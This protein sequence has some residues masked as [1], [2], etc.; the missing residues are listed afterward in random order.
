VGV[1]TPSLTLMEIWFASLW[2]LGFFKFS[3]TIL[4]AFIGFINANTLGSQPAY[5]LELGYAIGAPI[6]AGV[7]AKGGGAGVYELMAQMAGE[8][9]GFMKL[10]KK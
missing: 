9:I 1:A 2:G 6:L 5:S 10:S 3:L 4:G 7:I 8:V